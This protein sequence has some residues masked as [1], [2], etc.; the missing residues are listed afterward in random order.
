MISVSDVWSEVRPCLSLIQLHFKFP[1]HGRIRFATRHKLTG[2]GGVVIYI[3]YILRSDL[4]P[5]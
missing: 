1:H 4:S 2:N 5:C 3:S